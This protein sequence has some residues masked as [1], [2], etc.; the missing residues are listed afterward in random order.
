M[1]P[2]LNPLF[3]VDEETLTS[4]VLFPIDLRPRCFRAYCEQPYVRVSQFR[5]YT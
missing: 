1:A 4:M 2:L 3:A 5:T